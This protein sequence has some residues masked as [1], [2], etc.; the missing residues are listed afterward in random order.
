M[1]QKG[2]LKTDF[3]LKRI[4]LN[5]RATFDFGQWEWLGIVDGMVSNPYGDCFWGYSAGLGI[6]KF[7]GKNLVGWIRFLNLDS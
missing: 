3:I 7:Q 4:H 1:A 6:V 2:C 5:I